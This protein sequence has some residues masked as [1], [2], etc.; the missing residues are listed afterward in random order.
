[1]R[2]P[3]RVDRILCVNIANEIPVDAALLARYDVQGPRYT[4]YPPAPRFGSGFD[5]GAFAAAARASNDDPI[6]RRLSLY[7]HAPFCLSP[8]FYCGCARIITRDPAPESPLDRSTSNPATRA[9]R[10]SEKLV[11]AASPTESG[12]MVAARDASTRTAARVESAVVAVWARACALVVAV[13]VASARTR[14]RS[15]VYGAPI[16]HVGRTPRRPSSRP[17]GHIPRSPRPPCVRIEL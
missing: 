3:A 5:A 14:K 4:S 9:W 11:T 8:C 13:S 15:C 6:P 12:T 1:M 17:A 10:R 16:I 2:S 7:V